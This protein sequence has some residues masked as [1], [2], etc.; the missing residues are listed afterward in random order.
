MSDSRLPLPL[1]SSVKH[2]VRFVMR[3]FNFYFAFHSL[4]I[5]PSLAPWS[6]QAVPSVNLMAIQHE[7]AKAAQ[8]RQARAK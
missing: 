4:F 5:E 7:E 6:N 8:E 1:P 3:T 2:P